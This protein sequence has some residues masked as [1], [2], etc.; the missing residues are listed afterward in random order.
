MLYNYKNRAA[1]NLFRTFFVT[2]GSQ[3]CL[4]LVICRAVSISHQHIKESTLRE[5]LGNLEDEELEDWITQNDWTKK[6]DELI[7]VTNQE[8]IVKSK[9]IVDKV[10]FESKSIKCITNIN[11]FLLN[12]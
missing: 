8:E 11:N 10:N 5:L 7:F 12:S 6:E 4:A 1:Q 3:K 2:E 9:S